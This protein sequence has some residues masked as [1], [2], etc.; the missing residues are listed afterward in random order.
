MAK[1]VKNFTH[2]TLT[3]RDG[4]TPP[5][6]LVVDLD[7]GNLSFEE[8]EESQGVMSRGKPRA[9]ARGVKEMTPVS[10][11]AHYTEFVSSSPALADVSIADFLRGTYLDG[12][13]VPGLESVSDCGP[14]QVD[15]LWD[16]ASDCKAGLE[17]N[18]QIVFEQFH[19]DRKAVQEN[20]DFDK[21]TIT[22]K[23]ITLAGSRS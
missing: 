4:S 20:E 18:E 22:G 8:I 17:E 21:I 14:H 2:G 5:K 19:A 7:D 1:S 10:F 6:E 12:T 13:P 23:A 15:L 9:H 3:I 11:S 16:I